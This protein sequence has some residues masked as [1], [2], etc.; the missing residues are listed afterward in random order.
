MLYNEIMPSPSI[1]LIKS[2]DGTGN[3]AMA[4]VQS[5]RAP[6]ASTIIVDTV[7]NIPATFYGAMG[8]P[9]TF[10]DP[11]T[12]ETI[13][14]ISEA[15]SRD[16][17]GHVDGTNLEIDAMAPGNTDLGSSAGDV[18]IIKP[19]T[20]W[21]NNIATTFAVAHNDDGSLKNDSISSESLFTDNIDP[22]KRDSETFF[23]HVASGCV[24]SG[25]AYGSTLN[26]SMGT[27]GASANVVYINGQRLVISN[28]TA[29][30][31]TASKDTY[32]DVL[33]TAGVGSL[34]Y[35]EVTNNA[36]SPALAANSVRIGIIV[37]GASNIANV[38]SVNQGQET[39]VL[40]IAS[41]I[42]YQVTDSLGNLICPRDANRKVLGYRQIISNVSNATTTQALL[43]SAAVIVPTGRKVKVTGRV[44]LS[45][46]PAISSVTTSLWEGAVV[47]GTQIA[48]AKELHAIAGNSVPIHIEAVRTPSSAS[49][50]Y[51]FGFAPDVNTETAN[52]AATYPLY[53]LVEL[54]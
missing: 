45:S 21:A 39:K 24:W 30:A 5:T 38:G 32:I 42:P 13:T 11:I 50:T 54:V 9:H 47:A 27:G 4:T 48:L 36:A 31:F 8:T 43:I 53:I 51:S 44:P 40:P 33:N 28:V 35:T 10:V 29:R 41:S 3:A 37:T 46:N 26:A 23:D 1:N 2:S 25:D 16:F 34:V 12:A 52:C 22:V 15:T 19:T 18:I 20:E 14:V 17:E 7:D 49:Q 6:G